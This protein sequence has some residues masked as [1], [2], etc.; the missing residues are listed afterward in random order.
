[1]IDRLLEL[2]ERGDAAVAC[3]YCGFYDHEKQ[4]AANMV[5]ALTKQLVNALSV[6]PTEIKEAFRGVER[7]VGGR[8]SSFR[9][10]LSSWGG[11]LHRWSGHSFVLMP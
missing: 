11:P 8:G 5:G 7:E 6:V 9:K 1:M 3:V 2:L 4:T 10:P